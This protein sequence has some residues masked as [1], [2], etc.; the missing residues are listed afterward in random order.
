MTFFANKIIL[1]D[2]SIYQH[3]V[4]FICNFIYMQKIL[5]WINVCEV[6]SSTMHTFEIV[7]GMS[8]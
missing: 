3:V 6:Q 2:M 8:T 5:P 4:H 1:C 7:F